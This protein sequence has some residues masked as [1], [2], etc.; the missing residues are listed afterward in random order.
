[1]AILE[2]EISLIDGESVVSAKLIE[3]TVETAVYARRVAE[4]VEARANAGEFNGKDAS[5]IKEIKRVSSD[6]NSSTYEIVFNDASIQPY[7]FT[8]RNGVGIS[9][10]QK[11]SSQDNVSQD[12]VDTYKVSLTDGSFYTFDVTNGVGISSVEQ[13]ITSEVSGGYNTIRVTLQDGRSF[14]F[15]VKNGERG[16][17]FEIAKTYTS[18]AEMNAGF[19]TDGV[20]LNKFVL[21]ENGNVNDPENA[22]LYIKKNTGYAYLTDLSG[23][24]GIKGETGVGVSKVEKTSTNGLVDTYTITLTNG[25]TSTFTVTNGKKGD[26]GEKGESGVASITNIGTSDSND[27]YTLNRLRVDYSTGGYSEFEVKAKRGAQGFT[28]AQGVGVSRI[29]KIATNGLVD[30]YALYY[31]DATESRFSVTNGKDGT[32]IVSASVIK[33]GSDGND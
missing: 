4:N 29:A 27:G 7:Q 18:V 2:K 5:S 30:T 10:I 33:L 26:T 24:Q 21:I 3:D 22:R 13:V 23:S 6:V 19:A 28:G 9:G 15:K 8:V 25:N 1:M 11:L 17:P 31:T 12:N 14:E 16:D 32:S 20:Y